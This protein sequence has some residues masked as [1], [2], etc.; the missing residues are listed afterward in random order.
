MGTGEDHTDARRSEPAGPVNFFVSY[1]GADEAWA[2]WVAEVLEGNGQ[3]VRVQA[4][5]SPAGENFV[6]WISEQM[7]AA[8]RT[9][10]L[11]SP[12]YFDSHWCTQ[13]W[14]GALAGK[15]LTP[16]RVAEC[17][18]PAVLSTISYRDLHG[19]NE[20]TARRRLL[21]A[22]GLVAVARTSDGFPGR[23]AAGTGSDGVVFPGAVPEIFNVPRRLRHF[24][25]RQPLLERIGAGLG[26]GDPVAVTA[27]H[28]MGGVGKTQLAVEYAHR[29]A[30]T[31]GLVW[32]IDAE[33]T[34]LVAG[35]LAALAARLELPTTGRIDGDAAL[36]LDVL[37]QR[38]G[39]LLVYDNADD[40][41]ALAR[42]LP[43]G[44]G[45][46]LITSR[47]PGWGGLADRIDV[48]VMARP[49]A[50]A[51]LTRRIT[52]ITPDL[53]ED[54]AGE[55]G[56]LPLALEQAA[57]YLDATGLPAT[58]YLRDVRT[59]RA[60]MLG[61]GV[62]LAHGG[63]LTTLWTL[64]VD[65][66]RQQS[67]AAVTLLDLCAHLGPEP[68]PLAFLRRPVT[69]RRWRRRPPGLV[70]GDLDDAVGAV[71]R[72]SLARRL[73]ETLMVHRLVAAVIRARQTG[74]R[75]EQA[76]AAVRAL[77]VAHRPTPPLG[78]PAGW[79]AWAAITPQILT[80]PALH[81][82][83]PRTDIG[84]AA[85]QLLLDAGWT[86]NQRGEPRAAR[87]L[88]AAL[89]ER[90]STALGADHPY[91]LA[92]A[93]YLANDL[94]QLGDYQGAR[95]LD[96]DTL[97][98]C[99]RV[100]GDNH[101]DTLASATSLAEDLHQLGDYTS[102]RTL[103]EDTLARFRRVLGNDHPDT[104]ASANNLAGDLPKLGDYQGARTL[105]EDTL[106]RRRRVLG[107]DHPDTLRSADNLSENLHQ[108]G[109]TEAAE[110]LQLLDAQ[111]PRDIPYAE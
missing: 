80:A 66:L 23:P 79:E 7:D 58:S 45:H 110:P 32:W 104:L 78:D 13:E 12:A 33:Q 4:W 73:G 71:V 89:H 75:H 101:P 97:A 55:L 18:L 92:S 40:P 5:D 59:R 46:V 10:A 63:T 56:D 16:L 98:R 29:H 8:D 72:Y 11:C 42:W 20:A 21:E 48:D 2:T 76:A 93:G 65:R 37:R 1:T 61:K 41:E 107:D 64:T 15:K 77:L 22:A 86:L 111:L 17:R 57:A 85:R 24:T 102:A 50:V 3:T 74:D 95:T 100:L 99:R 49:D 70:A 62:D 90:W 51:F 108:L 30:A 88:H 84:T 109:D 34:E 83:N 26:E 54:L 82:D 9:L 96:E 14:T 60:S 31:Y 67:P 53:A 25:G 105:N 68:V 52:G 106:A 27:L 81:P 35:Q 39:W 28:G 19:V 43:D 36:I 91:T 6:L 103:D 87:T 69:R 94:H 44:P 47:H 38:E